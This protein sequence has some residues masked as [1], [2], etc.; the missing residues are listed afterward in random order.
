[1]SEPHARQLVA[2]MVG[3]GAGADIGKT[4]RRAM[5]LDGEYGLQAGVFGRNR[6]RSAAMASQLGIPE[7]RHY[8]GYREMAERKRAGRTAS[9]WWLLRRRTTATSRSPAPF[10]RPAS[11]WCA[12]SR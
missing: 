6:A 10:S 4:H 7:D 1:M 12:K 3:G 5:R 11:R 9:M 8:A 2:G